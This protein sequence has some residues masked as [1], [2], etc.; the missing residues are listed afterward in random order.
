MRCMRV[1][2]RSFCGCLITSQEIYY[3]F[4][5]DGNY[6]AVVHMRVALAAGTG[7]TYVLIETSGK[8]GQ[9]L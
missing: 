4:R 2:T 8:P 5:I 1:F 7:E 6:M 9:A 3:A